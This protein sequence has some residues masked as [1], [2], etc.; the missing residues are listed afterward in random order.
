MTALTPLQVTLRTIVDLGKIHPLSRS[1][2]FGSS[3]LKYNPGTPTLKVCVTR[4]YDAAL[5]GVC[6]FASG[7]ASL[8]LSRG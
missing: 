8:P 5:M 3:V 7:K 1:D 6:L 2:D 4:S